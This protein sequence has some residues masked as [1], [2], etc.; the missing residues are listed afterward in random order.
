MKEIQGV[1]APIFEKPLYIIG[2]PGDKDAFS[3]FPIL[4]EL[5]PNA[6]PMKLERNGGHH[7]IFLHPDPYSSLISQCVQEIFNEI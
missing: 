4:Q 6:I 7:V 2:T 5:Y 3:A 1:S